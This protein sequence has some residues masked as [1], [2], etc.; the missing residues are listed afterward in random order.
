MA[1]GV[2]AFYGGAEA[3]AVGGLPEVFAAASPE[4]VEVVG[5]VVAAVKTRKD[6]GDHRFG[7]CAD[8]VFAAGKLTDADGVGGVG[9]E[10][11]LIDVETYAGDGARYLSAAECVFNEYAADFAVVDIDV[12][13]PFDADSV[14][15]KLAQEVKD[16]E[17]HRLAD[18]EL[19]RSVEVLR[20][21]HEAEGD[22]LA[23]FRL[24]C[25]AALTAPCRLPQGHQR[26]S[27]GG[28]ASDGGVGR[29]AFV[30]Y[31]HFHR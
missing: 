4:V 30:N 16:A 14:D 23:R 22:V 27:V 11:G 17:S 20:T 28:V 5:V 24:P 9:E 26:I 2:D 25:V 6:S 1:V 19:A 29:R 13:G 12:V 18:L 21:Q 7:E 10:L 8:G 31:F 15:A 3:G